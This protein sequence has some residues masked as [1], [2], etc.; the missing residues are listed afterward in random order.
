MYKDIF[1]VLL[2]RWA[3]LET[4]VHHALVYK[5][6]HAKC[7]AQSSAPL[8]WSLRRRRTSLAD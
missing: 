8:Q 4:R 2:H 7:V 5:L 3:A 6:E 1:V